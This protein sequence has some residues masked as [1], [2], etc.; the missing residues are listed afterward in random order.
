MQVKVL[1]PTTDLIPTLVHLAPDFTA[2]F[3]GIDWKVSATHN[4]KVEK[5]LGFLIWFKVTCGPNQHP[6]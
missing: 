6:I 5:N 2:A 4:I 1:I 3:T